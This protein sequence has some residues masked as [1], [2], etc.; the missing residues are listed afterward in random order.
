MRTHSR[1]MSLAAVAL[2]AMVASLPALGQNSIQFT[3][4]TLTGDGSVVPSLRWSTTPAATSCTASGDWTGSKGASGA[5]TLPAITQGRTYNLTCTWQD[6]RATLRWVI[7]TQNTDG[8][9]LTDLAGFRITY[10]QSAT[11]GGTTISIDDPTVTTRV[12]Q[13]L[14]PGAWYFWVQARNSLGV[15]SD[16]SNGATKILTAATGSQ[17]VGITVN[18]KPSA[19][20]SLIAE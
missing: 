10:G 3:A 8:S 5:E 17:S 12:I 18:P 7:P 15:F 14:A 1:L 2:L 6:D 19:P 13:P 16:Y 4:D 9:P 20:T 11:P